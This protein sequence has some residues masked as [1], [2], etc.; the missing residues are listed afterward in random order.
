MRKAF[1][2]V[3]VEDETIRESVVVLLTVAEDVDEVFFD[4]ITL[5]FPRPFSW[6]S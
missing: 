1:G 4:D 2:L 5:L 6:W 3:G